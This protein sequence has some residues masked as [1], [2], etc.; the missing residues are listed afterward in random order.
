MASANRMTAAFHERWVGGIERRFFA[1]LAG[2]AR[3]GKGER[4]LDL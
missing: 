2:M 4:R 3:R 1:P